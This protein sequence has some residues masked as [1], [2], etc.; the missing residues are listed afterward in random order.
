MFCSY[1]NH[2]RVS[3][4]DLKQWG[5]FPFKDILPGNIIAYLNIDFLTPPL[6]H[7]IHFLLIKFSNINI[8]P[9]SKQ[10]HTNHILIYSAIV[11]ISAAKNRIADTGITQIELFR[12]FKIFLAM[13]IIA[14][15][16][17]KNKSIT[18]IFDISA[19]RHMI[20]SR[21]CFLSI[22]FNPVTRFQNMKF[23]YF[24]KSL[25]LYSL[26]TV[27]AIVQFQNRKKFSSVNGKY[28][29]SIAS[30]LPSF[31]FSHSIYFVSSIGFVPHPSVPT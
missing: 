12:V 18:P 1:N 11:H 22:V 21:Y 17:I 7:K 13:N 23:F 31:A 16:V 20:R 6:C 14:L 28:G 4:S 15:N 27:Y 8:I 25:I 5:T 26:K 30:T 9:T 24:L 10:L 29:I 3:I 19:H 2:L